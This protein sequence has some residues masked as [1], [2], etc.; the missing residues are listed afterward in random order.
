M[1]NI[2]DLIT[3]ATSIHA[4]YNASRIERETVREWVLGLG[5]YPQPYADAIASAAAWFKPARTDISADALKVQ[6]LDCLQTI[7]GAHPGVPSARLGA[8]R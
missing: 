1:K 3:S 8:S 6:D 4:R 2:D 5:G 7:A